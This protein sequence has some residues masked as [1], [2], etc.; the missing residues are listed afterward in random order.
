MKAFLDQPVLAHFWP[1]TDEEGLLE[2]PLLAHIF[3]QEAPPRPDGPPS[4]SGGGSS[5]P[6]GTRPGSW[7]RSGPTPKAG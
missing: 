5:P 2:R 7:W 6:T 4:A 3:A 1:R